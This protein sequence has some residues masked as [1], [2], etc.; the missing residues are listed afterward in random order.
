MNWA[1]FLDRD[2]T[3]NE[4]VHY[5]HEPARLRLL[6]RSPEAIRILNQ[7][8]IL[9]IL[10]TNQAGIGRGHF[11]ESAMHAVHDELGRQLASQG[12]HLDAVYFCPHQPDDGCSCRKPLPGLLVRAAQDLSLDLPRCVMVGDK[13]SDLAAGW[14]AGCRTALVL[15]GYGVAAQ[16]ELNDA[17]RSPDYVGRDLLEVVRWVLPGGM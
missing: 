7:A 12:A 6:P 10:V 3:V 8:G 2:G 14:S 13:V 5:L 15:S 11:P 9:A 16:C 17:D 1:V 4:E